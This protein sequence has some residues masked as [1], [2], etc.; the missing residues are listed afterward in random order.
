M[1]HSINVFSVCVFVGALVMP[2][3][4]TWLLR[5]AYTNKYKDMSTFPYKEA[6]LLH[7]TVQCAVLID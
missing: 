4:H 7:A 6:L 2:S 1:C 5:N 3:P